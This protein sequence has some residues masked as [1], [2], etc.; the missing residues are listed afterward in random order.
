MAINTKQ[1]DTDSVPAS[2]SLTQ[3]LLV[4]AG[5]NRFWILKLQVTPSVSGGDSI[6]QFFYDNTFTGALAL[7]ARANSLSPF[8]DPV[9]LDI[10]GNMA[11][12]GAGIVGLYEDEDATGKLHIKIFNQASI[13]R[14]YQVKIWYLVPADAS[15]DHDDS[16]YTESEID[17][18][19]AGLVAKTLF[20]ANTI[21]K[22]DSDNTPAALAVSEQRIL[23]RPTGGDIDDLTA[24]QVKGILGVGIA[25]DNLV[26][27][28]Q[29]DAASGEYTRLTANGLESRSAAETKADLDLEAG[30]DFFSK[31]AEETWRNSVT[32]GEMGFLH[33]ITSSAQTQL[34]AKVAKAL[35]TAHS[36]LYAVAAGTPAA[37]AVSEQRILGRPTGGD[38]ADLT[39]AEVKLILGYITA[40][41]AA[42]VNASNHAIGNAK[43]VQFNS[44]VDN[45]TKTA[46]FSITLDNG[47]KQKVTLTANTMTIT[48]IR[49]AG[50]GDFRIKIINGGLAA[51][52]WVASSGAIHWVGKTEP[53]LTSSGY[54]MIIFSVDD[55]N[56]IGQ[57]AINIGAA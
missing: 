52:T 27:I 7:E 1:W 16:Y 18:L 4:G 39:E 46:D 3:S 26:E 44:E 23:G 15:H 31:A 12:E 17:A 22:A 9:K 35:F 10:A 51:I 57:A 43:T 48:V 29:A 8:Y 53:L 19:L 38:I 36:I 14:T 2:G 11:Q 21:L 45:G 56:I 28:D 41:W 32:Q 6:Y 20:D 5:I 30:T 50:V 37:L 33:G 54:D 49:P 40:V 55:T 13:A 42:D 47:Q 25:D 24:A 34:D